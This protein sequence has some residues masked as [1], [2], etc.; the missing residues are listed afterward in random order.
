MSKIKPIEIPTDVVDR[1]ISNVPFPPGS[2][3]SARIQAR[4][5][6]INV[7]RDDLSAY[8]LLPI[9]ELYDDFVESYTENLYLAFVSS[10]T[11]VGVVAATCIA[12]PITQVSFNTHRSISSE[13]GTANAFSLIK[14]ILMGSKTDKNSEMRIFLKNPSSGNTL[15]NS[16]HI[17]TQK[18]IL[19]LREIF[20]ETTVKMLVLEEEI[21][22]SKQV[23]LAGIPSLVDLFKFIRPERFSSSANFKLSNV[24]ALKLD[25]YR[26]YSHKIT[27]FDVARSIEGPGAGTSEDIVTCIWVSQEHGYMYVLLDE[28]KINVQGGFADSNIGML[29]MYQQS[30]IKRMG[31]WIVKGIPGI[32]VIEPSQIRIIDIV[33][34]IIKLDNHIFKVKVSQ[35]NTRFGASL[36]DLYN[37]F[38]KLNINL[39][40]YSEQI[41]DL[42][43]VVNYDTQSFKNNLIYLLSFE[44]VDHNYLSQNINKINI[45]EDGYIIN[46]PLILEMVVGLKLKTKD[47]IVIIDKDTFFD[48]VSNVINISIDQYEKFQVAKLKNKED[49]SILRI[50][51]EQF[52]LA[53][54][55]YYIKTIGTNFEEII[56]RDD[57]DIFRSYPSNAHKITE[58]FGIDAGRLYSITQ[59]NNTLS[60]YASNVY[61]DPRHI[62]LQ[63]DMM[64]N[65]GEV[66]SLSISGINRRKLGPLAA[67]SNGHAMDSIINAS[68]QYTTESSKGITPAVCL[69]QVNSIIGT[70]SVVIDYDYEKM[71]SNEAADVMT[72]VMGDE[73]AITMLDDEEE[74]EK[75]EIT[76][77]DD[78]DE[79][80]IDESKNNLENIS[81]IAS[82]PLLLNLKKWK[83]SQNKI[84]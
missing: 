25:T 72:D 10:G 63:F 82:S 35:F 74:E 55:F 2:G 3:K 62:L 31:D 33:K 15:H 49:T 21:L 34:K 50:D 43:V 51:I 4:N 29:L 83:L 52:T 48:I 5:N 42:H 84:H 61:L 79:L 75:V 20:E 68:F 76:M 59:F 38:Y 71:T 81:K 12:A 44:Q 11:P 24:L 66:D 39:L 17:G 69:G 60:N 7:I 73:V 54:Q 57:V 56:W 53:S 23:I 22:D 77:L 80:I 58:L 37:M 8:K 28:S 41:D 65:L 47:N 70:S 30:I 1:I 13:S 18:M 9:P 45:H 67:A 32:S 26:M 16:L 46:D 64:T 14:N 36:L 78:E 27:M 6:L 19:N 40:G